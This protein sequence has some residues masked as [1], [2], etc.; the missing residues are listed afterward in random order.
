LSELA[1]ILGADSGDGGSRFFLIN[2]VH[3]VT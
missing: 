3:G 2:W 1:G